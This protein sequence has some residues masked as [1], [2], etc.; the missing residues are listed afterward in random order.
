[1]NSRRSAFALVKVP[2]TTRVF[3]WYFPV[4]GLS[5]MGTRSCHLRHLDFG[6]SFS[7]W[8]MEP[9]PVTLAMLLTVP[10]CN[11]GRAVV[12]LEV[13]CEL[14]LPGLVEAQGLARGGD[15]GDGGDHV[16]GAV[17]EGEGDN[18]EVLLF[19]GHGAHRLPW[20]RAARSP[21]ST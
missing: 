14:A 16:P 7:I 4:R 13:G 10:Y 12:P 11:V 15:E 6:L 3:C 21:S 19:L 17:R 5:P 9:S 2:S 8:M 20:E 18:A 1:M